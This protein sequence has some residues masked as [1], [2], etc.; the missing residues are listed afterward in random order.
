MPGLSAGPRR[1]AGSS[2]RRVPTRRNWDGKPRFTPKRLII[3]GAIL[4]AVGGAYLFWHR[5]GAI[6]VEGLA[7]GA[8]LGRR[9]V[10]NHEIR[11]TVDG[12]RGAPELTVNNTSIGAPTRDGSGVPWQH[13]PALVGTAPPSSR[14]SH[15]RA[16]EAGRGHIEVIV[17]PAEHGRG[18]DRPLLFARAIPRVLSDEMRP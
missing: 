5:S 15:H 18:R 13:P 3:A 2:K 14:F 17:R 4:L 1:L 8:S 7:D 6:H 11:I 9:A 16:D 12:G 10:N